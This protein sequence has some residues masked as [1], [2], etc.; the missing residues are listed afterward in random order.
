MIE[1]KEIL[2]INNKQEIRSIIGGYVTQTKNNFIINKNNITCVSKNKAT[3]KQIEDMI[4]AFKVAKHVKSNAI[5]LVFNKQTI[6]IGAGQMSRIDSCKIAIKKSKN[7]KRANYVAASD[8]FF[9][10][11]DNIT[12]LLRNSCKAIVQPAGSINDE[13]IIE[14]SNN[15]NLPLY[16]A[17]YRVFKH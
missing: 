11:T 2:N 10:F 12:L 7:Q 4:F 14:Y 15:Y 3:N 16:F 9:P 17:K 8:A 1:I 13:K 6:G 5:V